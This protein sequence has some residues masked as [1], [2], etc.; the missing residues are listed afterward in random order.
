MKPIFLAMTGLMAVVVSYGQKYPD[1]EFSNEIYYFKKDSSVLVRLEKGTSKMDTKMKMAGYGGT[2]TGY[3]IDG[4]KS[5]TR[6]NGGTNLSFVY[7]TG[8]S[9]SSSSN[10]RMDSMMRA[11]GAN[12]DM[13]RGASEPSNSI[14][15][16]KAESLKDKRKVY[17]MKSPGVINPFGSHKVQSSEKFTFSAKKVRDGYWELFVDKSLPK[18]EYIFTMSSMGMSGMDGSTLMFAFAVD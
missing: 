6:V 4:Q 7:F 10:A 16:Y 14:T 15:L 5:S 1:P 3:E 13:M 17:L 12:M 18:G 8:S 11:N 2:E 9:S